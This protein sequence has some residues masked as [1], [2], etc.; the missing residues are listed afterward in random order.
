MKPGT[1]TITTF[2]LDWLL[3]PIMLAGARLTVRWALA[4]SRQASDLKVGEESFVPTWAYS[5]PLFVTAAAWVIAGFGA[6]IK[7]DYWEMRVILKRCLE[8]W[9]RT[10]AKYGR[11]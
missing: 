3:M 6:L 4:D 1:F 5:I 2:W 9:R 7:E 10:R 11:A 8:K